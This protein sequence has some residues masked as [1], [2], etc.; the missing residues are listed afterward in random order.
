MGASRWRHAW[1]SEEVDANPMTVKKN[2]HGEDN[3]AART[4]QVQTHWR[5]ADYSW[6]SFIHADNPPAQQL[7]IPA[8][9]GSAEA[10]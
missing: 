5:A 7:E 8:R 1:R 9:S 10:N 3:T 6:A 2:S 4:G